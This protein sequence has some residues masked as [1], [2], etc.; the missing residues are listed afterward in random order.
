V[1]FGGTSKLFLLEFSMPSAAQPDMPAIWFL[2]GQIPRVGQYLPGNCWASGCGEM[3][4]FEVLA[5][6]T[7]YL[8]PTVHAEFH[9]GFNDY[10]VR[11]TDVFTKAA[12]LMNDDT[13][14]IQILPSDFQISTSISAAQIQQLQSNSNWESNNMASLK[15]VS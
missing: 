9:G 10:F 11:P 5:N 13:V 7:N 6:G 3:D 12:I 8:T 2:N 1:G 15:L 4:I 14:F